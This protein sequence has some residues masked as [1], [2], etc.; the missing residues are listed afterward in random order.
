MFALSRSV[1]KKVSGIDAVHIVTSLS[2]FI[3]NDRL[4]P[5]SKDSVK[6]KRIDRRRLPSMHE[7]PTLP[8]HKT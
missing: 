3:L 7:G 2:S 6:I 5:L 8:N 4:C 1:L